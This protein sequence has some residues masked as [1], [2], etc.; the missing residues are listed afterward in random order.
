MRTK[1]QKSTWDQ[2]YKKKPRMV[3]VDDCLFCFG[4]QTMGTSLTRRGGPQ[5]FC[6]ACGTRAF[7]NKDCW[8]LG[9]SVWWYFLRE[10][11]PIAIRM[12]INKYGWD[13]AK[14]A[15]AQMLY[16]DV[17]LTVERSK[18]AI[19]DAHGPGLMVLEAAMAG[20]PAGRPDDWGYQTRESDAHN[21]FFCLAENTLTL[22]HT[23]SKVGR[24]PRPTMFCSACLTRVYMENS[25]SWQYGP[26]AWWSL[27]DRVTPFA[28]RL[29]VLEHGV[30]PDCESEDNIAAEI[31]PLQDTETLTPEANELVLVEGERIG[32]ERA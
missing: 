26:S 14:P 15:I 17:G 19:A 6:R 29:F 25:R 4:S 10:R 18:K 1:Y 12:F 27:I 31:G 13:S 3:N 5:L 22:A 11:D 21:C 23:K 24:A 16:T 2:S 9:P 8:D 30:T 32:G 20:A 28:L 7:L